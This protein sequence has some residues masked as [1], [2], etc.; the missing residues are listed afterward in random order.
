[1]HIFVTGELIIGTKLVPVPTT[2]NF[3]ITLYGTYAAD[4]VVYD[5][6]TEA[7]NKVIASIGKVDLFGSGPAAPVQKLLVDASK[8]EDFIMIATGLT[9]WKVGSKIYMGPTGHQYAESDYSTIKAYD[10]TTGKV[11]LEA[12]LK[13][14]H[15]GAAA[16]TESKYKPEYGNKLDI[17]TD[18][19]YL[20]R[21]IMIQGDITENDKDWGG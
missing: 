18:V 5:G 12:K 3:K 17:R 6:V 7:G 2:D 10:G 14:Y 8:D 16:S 9:D 15:Y 20:S 19:I 1:M 13:F 21:S 4:T 11:T